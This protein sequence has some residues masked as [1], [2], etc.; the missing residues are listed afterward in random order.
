[1]PP[2]KLYLFINPDIAHISD[3]SSFLLLRSPAF[4]L[5][6]T[7]LGE[8]SAYV[9]PTIEVVTFRL[10]GWCMLDVFLLPAFTRL[11]HECQDLLSPCDGNTCVHRLHLGLYSH[12]KEFW[13]NE[14]RTH[15]ISK[16]NIPSTGKKKNLP[17]RR[18]E[19]VTLH[20]V[21]QRAQRTTN[22]LFRPLYL[23]INP[24]IAHISESQGAPKKQPP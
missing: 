11:G 19:P 13:K 22:E 1:M 24:D 18:N 3:S 5:G 8:I 2:H 17:Q 10:R 12:P 4:S 23:F 20:H 7:I 15:V 14:V 6:F 9:N 16:G 21:G